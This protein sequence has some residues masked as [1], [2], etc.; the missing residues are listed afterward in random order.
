MTANPSKFQSITIGNNSKHVD[1]FEINN[2]LG[3][4]VENYVALLGVQNE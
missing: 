4:K 1:E 3:I 2:D